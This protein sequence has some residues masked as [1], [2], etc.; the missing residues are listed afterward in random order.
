MPKSAHRGKS[1]KKSSKKV[2]KPKISPKATKKAKNVSK[3]KIKAS[4]R[5]KTVKKSK[6]KLTKIKKAKKTGKTARIQKINLKKS[7]KKKLLSKKKIILKAKIDVKDKIIVPVPESVPKKVISKDTLSILAR[8]EVRQWLI[9]LGGENTIS[10]IKNL[11]EVPNDEALAKKLKIRISDVRSS[12]NRLHNMGLVVYMR[13]KNSETGWYSYSWELSEDKMKKWVNEMVASQKA[14]V[15]KEGL[16]IY[17]CKGC[18]PENAIAFELAIDYSFKCPSC[19]TGLELL[20]EQRLEQ[21][22]KN[23][24][25]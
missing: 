14:M 23:Q 20:D 24:E 11:H 3:S 8:C 21:F 4:I 9:D 6:I 16:D 5:T 15:S 18:G 25:R 17:F 10:I 7:S 1:P 22:K 13:D 2:K 19:N 12:L